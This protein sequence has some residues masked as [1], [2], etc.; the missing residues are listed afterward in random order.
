MKCDSNLQFFFF[1]FS[2]LHESVDLISAFQTKNITIFEHSVQTKSP[3]IF[4]KR[5]V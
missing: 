5:F 4:I 3:D 1:F 2:M